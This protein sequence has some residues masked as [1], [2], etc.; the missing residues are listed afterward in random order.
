MSFVPEN[1]KGNL[2]VTKKGSR[3]AA[4]EIR[5]QINNLEGPLEL[6]TRRAF[7]LE[8]IFE[9]IEETVYADGTDAEKLEKLHE[10]ARMSRVTM[11]LPPR[12]GA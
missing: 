10:E 5:E 12:P 4:R 1:E 2:H 9:M 11:S 7:H 8:E 3:A 6:L